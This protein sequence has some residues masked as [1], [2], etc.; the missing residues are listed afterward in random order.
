VRALEMV[1]ELMQLE[2]E[3]AEELMELEEE[4]ELEVLAL[5]PTGG[6]G[7]RGRR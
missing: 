7:T 5:L 3:V 4:E 1:E 2:G 6:V